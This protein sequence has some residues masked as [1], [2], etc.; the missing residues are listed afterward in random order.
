MFLPGNVENSPAALLDVLEPLHRLTDA[1]SAVL[2]VHHPKKGPSSQEMSPR[3]SGA[4]TGFADI[5]IDLERTTHPQH[6]DRVRRLSVASRLGGSFRKHLELTPD[7]CDYLVLPNPP[8]AT[9]SPPAAFDH[10]CRKVFG[11][12]FFR[13]QKLCGRWTFF[14]YR[15][16][17]SHDF[18]AG[19]E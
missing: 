9:A 3:G 10:Q 17:C 6:S 19:A 12:A 7:G 4:L 11:G 1:G 16:F 18:A 8:N 5:L 14:A 13:G 2:L 15:H